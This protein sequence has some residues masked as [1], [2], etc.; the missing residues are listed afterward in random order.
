MQARNTGLRD[1]RQRLAGGGIRQLPDGQRP[2]R[3]RS[4]GDN[5]KRLLMGGGRIEE[6]TKE[7]DPGTV[8][9]GGRVVLELF[10]SISNKA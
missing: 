4:C 8:E 5:D 2:Q 7:N 1:K 3:E 6:G 9:T 10:L